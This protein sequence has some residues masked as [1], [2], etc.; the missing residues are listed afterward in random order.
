[1]QSNSKIWV[2]KSPFL[3]LKII[4][5][6]KIKSEIR[7]NAYFELWIF[8]YLHIKQ[9]KCLVQIYFRHYISQVFL[10]HDIKNT[11][12]WSCQL[13]PLSVTRK[14]QTR[15]SPRKFPMYGHSVTALRSPAMKEIPFPFSQWLASSGCYGICSGAMRCWI[16]HQRHLCIVT[17]INHQ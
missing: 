10:N 11:C 3:T 17:K 8:F 15:S 14:L 6:L 13:V 5:R 2:S 4:T 12:W 16:S 7:S 1:M 9:G